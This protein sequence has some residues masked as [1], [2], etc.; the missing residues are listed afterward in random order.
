MTVKVLLKL[1]K[2]MLKLFLGL[3]TL[4]GIYVPDTVL[5]PAVSGQTWPLP[6]WNLLQWEDK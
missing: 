1:N 2:M 3:K 4:V 6:S 5:G